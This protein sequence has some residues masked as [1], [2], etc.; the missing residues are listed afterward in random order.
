MALAT[1]V[2]DANG[3]EFNLQQVSSVMFYRP[4]EGC[5]AIYAL[6][7]GLRGVRVVGRDVL[8]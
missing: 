4:W 7:E 5:V 8:G 2:R 6:S 1:S 3:D